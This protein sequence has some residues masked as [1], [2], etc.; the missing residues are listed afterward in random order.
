MK[1]LQNCIELSSS[2]KIYVP[3]TIDIDQTFDN[4]EIIDNTLKFLC[5]EFGGATA[6]KAVGNWLVA[7]NELV[8]EDITL[9]LSYTTQDQ[10]EKSI[11]KVIEFCQK[12]KLDLR[13]QAIAIEVNNKLYLV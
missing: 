2:V 11:N 13:Q 8:K 9:V 4:A 12:M 3:S 6:S 1:I 7:P 10:L 5:L